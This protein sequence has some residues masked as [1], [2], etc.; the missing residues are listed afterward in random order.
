MLTNLN[1]DS[2]SETGRMQILQELSR[3]ASTVLRNTDVLCWNMYNNTFDET[4][5]KYLTEIDGY[6]LPAHMRHIPKQRPYLDWLTGRQ[7]DRP[8]QF[9]VS[10]TDKKALKRKYDS[11]VKFY[12]DEYITRWRGMYN[13]IG[14]GLQQVQQQKQEIQQQ[15]EQQPQNDEQA[16]QVAQLKKMMPQIDAKIATVQQSLQDQ[17]VFTMKNIK[18]L[19]E[20][21]RYTNKDIIEEVAQKAMK[22]YRQKLNV[23]QVS[24]QNFI[25]QCVTGKQY[26]Y[27]DYRPGDTLPI[28]RGL[29]GFNVFYQASDDVQW[30]QDLDWAGFE[31]FMAPQDV[32]SEFQLYG[33]YKDQV[34]RY[35]AYSQADSR[36]PFVATEDGKAVDAGANAYVSSGAINPSMGVSVKRVWWVAE[37]KIVALRKVNKYRPGRFFTTFINEGDQEKKLIDEHDYFYKQW[38]TKSGKTVSKWI[39]KGK[40]D[41]G[42]QHMYDPDEVRTYDSRRGD[43]VTHRYMY[44]RFKGAIIDNNIFISGKDEVQPRSVDNMSKV[45]LPI[46][47]TTYNNITMQPY[48]LI[49]AT[50]DIQKTYNI[51]TYHR[52]LMLAVAGTK[53]FIMDDVQKPEGMSD[54][55]WRRKVKMGDIRIQTRKKGV[56]NLQPSF[57]QFQAIDLSLSASVQYLENMLESLDNQMGLIM[58]ISRPAMG[59]VVNTDQ[60]GTFQ[61]SQ[62]S[63]LLV[64]EVMYAKHD[65]VERQALTMLINLARQYCWDKD[66]ILSYLNEDGEEEIVNIPAGMLDMDDYEI[67]IANNTLEERRLNELKSYALQNYA[68]GLLPFGNFVQMYSVESLKELQKKSVYFAEEAQRLQSEQKQAEGQQA[69]KLEEHRAQVQM[70]MQTALEKQKQEIQKMQMS[71]DS[72]AQKFDSYIRQAE[73]QL[74]KHEI[75]VKEEIGMA[76]INADVQ[77][78]SQTNEITDRHNRADEQIRELQA[79]MDAIQD[80]LNKKPANA[81]VS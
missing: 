27:V 29:I 21:Q 73:N 1:T 77:K 53:S 39:L 30:V 47:G 62:Q 68:K 78:T 16:Q 71:L 28:Y 38:Q 79:H 46:I 12:T 54:D 23:K 43:H 34:E 24:I 5:Y 60:V 25:S 42:D 32:I 64:T 69:M 13:Q 40:G 56:G 76:K 37:R 58:G 41:H 75:D 50:K 15:L 63:T 74:R 52:E 6:I 61:M 22:S 45:K 67:N 20:L 11:R 18:Q 33:T 7:V 2:Y 57:N 59:Q 44:D 8:F 49:W 66:T 36:G 4:E 70:Q 9:S 72:Q 10:C 14:A 51:V 48:S 26:Y 80:I 81:K 3:C 55:E 65:E 31:E 19:E 35:H 17:Q